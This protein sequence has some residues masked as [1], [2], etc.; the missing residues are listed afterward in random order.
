MHASPVGDFQWQRLEPAP[1]PVRES[2]RGG[3]KTVLWT[4]GPDFS[5]QPLSQRDVI[6]DIARLHR[7]TG[8]VEP[9]RVVAPEPALMQRSVRPKEVEDLGAA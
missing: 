6:A 1:L 9:R 4:P 5:K 8:Y 7:A 2:T 3:H